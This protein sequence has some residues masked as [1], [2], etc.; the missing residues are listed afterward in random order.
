MN[1][2][3]RLVNDMMI[4]CGFDGGA[5]WANNLFIETALENGALGAKL[6]GAGQGGSVFALVQPREE[7]QLAQVWQAVAHKN[8]LDQAY[9][10]FPRLAP[11]GLKV[12]QAG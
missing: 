6:T 9:I 10:Y 5:G 4:Y 3:H 1:V 12:E 2:N 7:D 11:H 8:G